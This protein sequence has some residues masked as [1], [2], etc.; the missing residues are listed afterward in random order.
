MRTGSLGYIR[1]FFSLFLLGIFSFSHAQDPQFGHFYNNA[2]LYNPAFAG[3]VDLGRIGLSY[4][5]QWPGVPGAFVSYAA[6]Y[7]HFLSPLKSGI[8]LQFVSDKAGSGGLTTRGINLMYSYQIQLNRRVAL[9]FGLKGGFQ[10]RFYD[11][12]KFTFADQIARDDAP[13]SIVNDFRERISYGNFG[14]GVV[15]YH[16]EKYWFGLAFDHLNQPSNSFGDEESVLPIRM[17]AQGGWN[18]PM[19]KNL[20]GEG[21]SVITAAFLYKTQQDWDQ[22]DVGA[23]YK[24]AP[25]LFGFW[26]RGLPFK[27][28]NSSIPNVDAVMMLIGY[29]YDRISF[30]YSF[31]PTISKLAGSTNGSHEIS[32]ILEYPKSRRPRKRFFRVPCPKF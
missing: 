15:V 13:T 19:N 26:Y 21:R 3:N 23:Y 29:K 1:Y 24:T 9:L 22:L 27:S 11:F 17:S 31:E 20:N 8:G 6:S 14:Q 4:R 28:N 2:M 18:F 30:A 10:S 16:I 5:N 32:L 7:E 12:N 25:L